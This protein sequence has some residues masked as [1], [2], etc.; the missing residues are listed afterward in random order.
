MSHRTFHHDGSVFRATLPAP[1]D[2]SL[3]HRALILAAMAPGRSRVTGLGPGDDVAATAA[4]IGRLGV[5]RQGS[6]VDSPGIDNW[7]ASDRAFDCGNSGTTM[8]LLAGALAGRPTPATL[9]GDASLLRRPMRRLVGPLE[10]LGAKVEISGKGTAPVTVHAPT[11]LRG[12]DVVVDLASAQVR[13]AV[14]LAALQAEGTTHIDGP[15]GFRDHTERWLESLGRG[16]ATGGSGF[17]V[18]PGALPEAD[19]PVPGDPSSAA[20]LWAAAALV[21]GSRVTTPGVSLNPG[22]VGFL[23]VLEQMGASVERRLTGAVHGDPVGDVVVTGASLRPADVSGALAVRALDELPLVA[24]LAAFADGVTVVADA[25]ELRAKESDRIAATVAMVRAFG[26]RGEP[27]ADGFAVTGGKRLAGGEV[28]AAGD[29]RIAMAAAVAGA[30]TLGPV[31]V[32]GIDAAA[33]SWPDFPDE[34]ERVWSSR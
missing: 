16:T 17:E 31:T 13:T 7:A 19:Y 12:T 26:G 3:S 10:A 30:A 23:E 15:P 28:Q 11:R 6:Y 9:T 1:G 29:H 4:A 8:R 27:S 22:R 18:R 33:V 21:P 5:A 32:F 24:V 14:A 34:L 2:K 20:F 25:G